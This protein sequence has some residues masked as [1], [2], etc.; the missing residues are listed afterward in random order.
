MDN[1]CNAISAV[2]GAG[3]AFFLGLNDEKPWRRWFCFGAA[4]T[5]AHVPMFA[6]SRGGMLGLIVMGLVSFLLIPKRPRHYA[7]F[8][9]AV[10]IGLRMA[11][12]SVIE[13]FVTVFVDKS[14]RDGSAQSRI[15]MWR[16]C[17]DLT[18]RFPLVGV[19]PN[20]F[21]VVAWKYGGYR[22]KEAHNL[23][24]QHGA[25]QG[26]PGL[27]LLVGIYGFTIL[28][29]RQLLRRSADLDPW[30]ADVARMV[31]ASLAGFFVS[32]TFVS[33]RG[34]ELPYYVALLGAA[35]VNLA[36]RQCQTT[37]LQRT[38]TAYPREAV[39]SG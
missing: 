26:I 4:A 34:L 6:Y 28:R 39:L 10:V 23:W 25:E 2:T 27:G 35:S 5:M 7:I 16:Q 30:F 38:E 22:G 19:G 3:L 17:V 15:D 31:I 1:N 8:A 37:A 9:L 12:P 18:I 20:H 21:P 24:F 29:L 36:G 11:G 14:E 32:S 13:R 33:L